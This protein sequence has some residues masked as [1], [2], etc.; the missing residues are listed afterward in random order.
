MDPRIVVVLGAKKGTI[1]H[2]KDAETTIGRDPASGLCLSEESVS[3]K[4]CAIQADGDTYRVIDFDSSNGTFVNGIPVGNKVLQ[5]GDRIRLGYS[6]LV[7]LLEPDET[8][9]PPS[10]PAIPSD[11][12]TLILPRAEPRLAFG[13]DRAGTTTMPDLGV[14]MPDL[15]ALL[16]IS[17]INTIGKVDLLKREL[18]DL[19]F[20]IIPAER[21]SVVLDSC[22]SPGRAT[23]W[24]R[25]GRK[26]ESGEVNWKIV[27]R[28]LWEG[29]NVVNEPETTDKQLV[30][31]QF[32]LCGQTF[33]DERYDRRA[34]SCGPAESA[35]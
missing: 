9:T 14:V 13:S 3:R 7:F 17:R 6:E 20:E 15:D 26:G 29:A 35:V 30:N 33:G 25:D 34:L 32:V 10:E 5:H 18:L 1:T 27:N 8:M 22:D 16:R 19:L 12:S 23:S 11:G 4:H 2:L 28:A 24:H 21:G 31:E